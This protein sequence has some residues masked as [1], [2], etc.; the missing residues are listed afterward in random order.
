MDILKDHVSSDAVYCRL[1]EHK[2]FTDH[3]TVEIYVSKLNHTFR[4]DMHNDEYKEFAEKL[5]NQ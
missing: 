4:I 5:A 2:A 3:V 1:L